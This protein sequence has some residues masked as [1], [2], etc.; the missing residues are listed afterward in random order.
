MK[1]TRNIIRKLIKESLSISQYL[2]IIRGYI[3]GSFE[4]LTN[5]AV[6]L[7]SMDIVRISKKTRFSGFSKGI[8]FKIVDQSFF[9][10]LKNEFNERGAKTRLFQGPFNNSAYKGKMSIIQEDIIGT[11]STSY[12]LMLCQDSGLK[13]EAK[14]IE[15]K[16]I[17]IVTKLKK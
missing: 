4:D 7:D 1:T 6:A 3:F 14:D 17:L 2:N 16:G 8:D 15:G 5:A 9:D 13:P 10:T 11:G 12:V